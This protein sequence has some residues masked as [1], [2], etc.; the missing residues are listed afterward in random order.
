MKDPGWFNKILI[1]ILLLV[2]STTIGVAQTSETPTFKLFLIGDAG[3]GDST[4]ATLH[5]LR[6]QL[7]KSP[8]SAVIFLGDNCYLKTYFFMP[9]EEGGYN[10]SKVAKRRIMAQLNILREYK[11]YAYFIPGNHDWFNHIS[12]RKGKKRLKAEEL[13]I[14]ENLRNFTNLKNHD[15][16]TFLPT[17][18]DPGPISKDFNGGK[19]R[20]IF[21]DTHRLIIEEGRRRHVDSLLLRTFYDELKVQLTDATNKKQKI[22]VVGHH[23]I[24]SKGKHSFP[25][26]F[27]ERL[28]RRFADSNANYPPYHRMAVH[29]DSLLKEHHHPDIYYVSGHEHSLEYFFNDSLHYLVSGAGS[30]VDNVG[31]E[32]CI[33]EGECLQWNQGGFFEIDF[34][35]RKETVLMYHRMERTTEMQIE[36]VS[37]CK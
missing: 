11:G 6:V 5:D 15:K 37:G 24:H 4:G 32:S 29:L 26:V 35:G 27:W 9:V 12:L 16:G 33:E 8:N 17:D 25:L 13:F 36:C 14:E 20:V 3:E 1:A 18:G 31:L 21:I 28:N 7:L 2:I 30:K 23:P 10:G 34:Y 19:T 22:I